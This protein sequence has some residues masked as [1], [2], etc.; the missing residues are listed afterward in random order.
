[1]GIFELSKQREGQAWR[2]VKDAELFQLWEGIGGEVHVVGSLKS[3]LLIHRD[4]DIHIYTEKVSIEES[5]S[6]MA[7]LAERL[8]LTSLQYGNLIDTEEECIEWHALFQDTNDDTWK[9]DLIHIRKG[10]MFD[11]VVEKATHAIKAKLTPEI[12]Q[13][14][15]QIKYD[16]PQNKIIPGIEVYR[17]V[18]DGKVKTYNELLQWRE[19]NPLI[20]SLTWMP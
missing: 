15:L 3:G 17:A 8:N 1:M 19:T 11:G 13:T 16:M 4:I 2:I 5:F 10:S 20:D 18:F 7:K 14:I 6:A 12:R 9:L